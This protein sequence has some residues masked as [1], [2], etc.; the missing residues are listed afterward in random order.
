VTSCHLVP[1]SRTRL[2]SRWIAR[3][4]VEHG[5][6]QFGRR[7]VFVL[8]QHLPAAAVPAQP[9]FGGREPKSAPKRS[10]NRSAMPKSVIG[11]GRSPGP[12][13]AARVEAADDAF[14]I[15]WSTSA[16]RQVGDLFGE[17]PQRFLGVA[18]LEQARGRS[19]PAPQ[20]IALTARR[21]FGIRL[22]SLVR[23]PGFGDALSAAPVGFGQRAPAIPVSRGGLPS[24]QTGRVPDQPSPRRAAGPSGGGRKNDGRG[25]W[26]RALGGDRAVGALARIG[27]SFHADRA[28]SPRPADQPLSIVASSWR[29]SSLPGLSRAAASRLK[30]AIVRRAHR[31][32]P[33][34]RS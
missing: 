10:R 27:G 2:A 11:S 16:L 6:D 23:Q 29:S 28:A 5:G 1:V 33:A 21:R 7:R 34:S 32:R 19:A 12:A 15:A 13:A 9:A 20:A 30:R 14:A 4:G 3:I 26:P 25:R 17:R 8:V 31:Q 18:F 22:Q 24:F